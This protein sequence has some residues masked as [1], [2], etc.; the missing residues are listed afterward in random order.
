V[1]RKIVTQR[2]QDAFW[3]VTNGLAPGDKI[4]TQGLGKLKPN[5]ALRPV[6]ADTPQRLKP[7]PKDGGKSASGAKGG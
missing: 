7:R 3:V 1:Q 2:T 4:I 6:P 5:A